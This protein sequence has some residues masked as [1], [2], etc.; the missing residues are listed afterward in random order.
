MTRHSG[1]ATLVL[2]LAFSVPNVHAQTNRFYVAATFGQT[3]VESPAH[4][5]F[6]TRSSPLRTLIGGYQWEQDYR[7]E[8]R[9]S[10][11][12]E[13]QTQR[14]AP[15]QL[16]DHGPNRAKLLAFLVETNAGWTPHALRVGPL[17][18]IVSAGV[19]VGRASETI[20]PDTPY[21]W[22]Q[23]KLLAGPTASVGLEAVLNRQLSLTGRMTYRNF[24]KPS[25]NPIGES[26]IRVGGSSWEAGVRFSP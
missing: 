7:T 6:S 18:P 9:L 8:A 15:G 12:S 26:R 23:A 19:I 22:G 4:F 3:K 16:T 17:Q 25:T 11:A 20:N 21:E 13:S 10:L 14:L 1:I 5:D 2:A 24:G